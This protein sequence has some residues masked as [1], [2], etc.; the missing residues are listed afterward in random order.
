ML[1]LSARCW[2]GLPLSLSV[3]VDIHIYIVQLVF[4]HLLQIKKN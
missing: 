4:Y 3:R 1:V 2:L